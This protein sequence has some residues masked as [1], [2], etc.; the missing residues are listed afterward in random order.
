MDDK[1][2]GEPVTKVSQVT[3]DKWRKYN[4]QK[5]ITHLAILLE[6]SEKLPTKYLDEIPK[7]LRDIA[8]DKEPDNWLILNNIDVDRGQSKPVKIPEGAVRIHF[9]SWWGSGVEFHFEHNGHECYIQTKVNNNQFLLPP[10]PDVNGWRLRHFDKLMSLDAES[11]GNEIFKLCLFL[12]KTGQH[13]KLVYELIKDPMLRA[14]IE[15][16][17]KLKSAIT[18]VYT[19]SFLERLRRKQMRADEACLFKLGIP[20]GQ[21]QKALSERYQT[22]VGSIKKTLAISK[23]NDGLD[24]QKSHI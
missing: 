6:H 14:S 7:A 3:L 9:V 12:V 17:D 5:F 15:Y 20:T 21:I 22:S 19:S 8:K 2:I 16:Q 23:L 10:K 24:T 1:F 13:Q 18:Y 4:K 11:F